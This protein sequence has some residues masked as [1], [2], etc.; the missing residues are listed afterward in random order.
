MRLHCHLNT[1]TDD[2]DDELDNL[3]SALYSVFV[4]TDRTEWKL[5]VKI[6]DGC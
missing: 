1:S 2:D 5:L 3:Y 4:S 6:Q